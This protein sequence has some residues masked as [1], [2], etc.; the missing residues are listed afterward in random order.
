MKQR[1]L[2]VENNEYFGR[3][4]KHKIETILDYQ[5][6]WYHTLDNLIKDDLDYTYIDLALVDYELPNSENG[7]VFNI[8]HQNKIPTILLSSEI[9]NEVQERIWSLKIIDYIIK[10]SHHSIDSIIATLKNFFNNPN[11]GI[12]IVDNS[13]ESREHLKKL[14]STHR[15]KVFEANDITETLKALKENSCIHL[16]ITDHLIP[17]LNGLELTIEIR[18]K[19]PIDRL[20]IIGLSAQGNH[21][22]KIQF[23]KNGANDFLNKP[24]ISEL[25]F[26]RITQNLKIVEYF[27]QLKKLALLDQLTNLNNRHFLRETGQIIFENAKRNGI[28]LVIA[29]IDIDNF[30]QVNDTYGHDAGDIVLKRIASILKES[31]RKSDIAIRYGGEEFVIV[32]NNFNPKNALAFFNK[33]R[34]KIKN[35]NI[36]INDIN[37]TVSVSIGLC[38]DKLETL[39]HMIN[40]A[41]SNMYEAK[42]TG[43]NRVC[44]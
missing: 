18:K 2:L 25:I 23:I 16:V 26:C 32:G 21:A 5:V 31:I 17:D 40:K 42:T 38:L 11:V 41:D 9:T 13:I 29:M 20:S 44:V 8:C 35:T 34:M 22:L 37:I 19:Y 30:K 10:G 24:F 43:K 33:L 36:L 27:H 15:Y 3:A 4:V 14:L 28:F 12:L 7:E 6:L 39:E 1:V